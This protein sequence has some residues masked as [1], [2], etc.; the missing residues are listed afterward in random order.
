MGRDGDI[1][2]FWRLLFDVPFDSEED[3]IVDL[4]PGSAVL[5]LSLPLLVLSLARSFSRSLA[6]THTHTHTHTN[7]HTHTLSPPG[8]R[9]PSIYSFVPRIGHFWR[10]Q[11]GNRL[12]W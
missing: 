5:S 4:H 8:H 6:R 7:T 11:E 10:E 3:G 2:N 12:R 9:G 1:I